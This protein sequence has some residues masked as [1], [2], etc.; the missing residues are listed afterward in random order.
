MCV[1]DVRPASA[2]ARTLCTGAGDGDD[3]DGESER[4]ALPIVDVMTGRFITTDDAAGDAAFNRT[5]TR[6]QGY[7][8]AFQATATADVA[9]RDNV[10]VVGASIDLADVAFSSTSEVG[11]LTPDR[12]VDGS[13]LLSGVFG[14]APDDQFNT[15]IDAENRAVGLYVT[16]TLSLTDRVHLTVSGRFNDVSVVIADRLG[17]SLDGHHTFARFNPGVGAVYQVMPASSV[18]ARVQRI[19]SC[20]DSGG[21]ELRR[22]G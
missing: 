4:E 3:D 11:T 9:A 12:T 5:A 15:D 20:A 19:E 22:S 2:P 7:G 6:A 14:E 13:G 17:S 10:L 1:D 21:A 8:A 18:F 16:D